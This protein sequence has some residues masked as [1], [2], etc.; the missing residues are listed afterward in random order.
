MPAN[1]TTNSTGA[2]AITPVTAETL[3][4]WLESAS[5]AD[6]EWL[7]T[8]GFIGEPG[9]FAFVPGTT[10]NSARVVFASSPHDGVW[11]YAGLPRSLPEG[12]YRIDEAL[13]RDA[14]TVTALG[15]SLGSYLYSRYKK[16]KRAWATLVWPD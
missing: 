5:A 7:R 4:A 13:D 15:W 12:T 9:T 1:L 11:A 2:I 16:P 8:T 14:A 6:R 10:G 3:P